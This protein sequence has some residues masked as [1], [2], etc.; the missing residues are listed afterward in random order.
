LELEK[1][2]RINLFR[3]RIK[4]IFKHLICRKD[5]MMMKTRKT[6]VTILIT[7]LMSILCV[8]VAMAGEWKQDDTGWWWQ[9][10]DGT[11][12]KG[13]WMWLDG[14]NDG[15]AQ[16]YYFDASGYMWGA[17]NTTPDGYTLNQEGQWIVDGVVQT[18][19]V[20]VK[21]ETAT[22]TSATSV[23]ADTNNAVDSSQFYEDNGGFNEYGVSNTAIAMFAGTREENAKYGEVYVYEYITFTDVYYGNGFAIEYPVPGC[24]VNKV[25]WAYKLENGDY[26]KDS[27]KL[28]KH[29][30]KSV[31]DAKKA[32]TYLIGKGWIRSG[33]GSRSCYANSETPLWIQAG[34]CALKWMFTH[35]GLRF[36][37]LVNINAGF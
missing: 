1:Q 14:D 22:D 20:E 9:N 36:V 18:K 19:Q 8:G 4:H 3:E 16:C 7:T 33:S 6:I 37:E 31:S 34:K 13:T 35:S 29:F 32:E 10:D 23:N 28:F 26:V 24:G 25:L 2:R 27:A 15:V 11:Y 12:V 5:E 21:T 30:D 17:G